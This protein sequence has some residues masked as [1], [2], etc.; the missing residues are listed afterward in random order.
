[1]PLIAQRVDFETVPAGAKRRLVVE[2]IPKKNGDFKH[3]SL[4]D[5]QFPR[6]LHA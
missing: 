6:D 2:A 3:H 4:K 5:V 1:M